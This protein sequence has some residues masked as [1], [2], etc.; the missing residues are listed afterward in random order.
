[1]WSRDTEPNTRQPA[2][3]VPTIHS[4]A[5]IANPARVGASKRRVN[6]KYRVNRNLPAW[7]RS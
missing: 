2:V 6:R 4:A 3:V 5:L 1:M 7:T